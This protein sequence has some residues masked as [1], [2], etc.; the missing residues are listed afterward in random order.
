MVYMI[1]CFVIEL[2]ISQKCQLRYFSLDY[3]VDS[4]HD[5][6]CSMGYFDYSEAL[7][8]HLMPELDS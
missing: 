7:Q 5:G 3:W 4:S 6:C 2:I 1:I 8:R